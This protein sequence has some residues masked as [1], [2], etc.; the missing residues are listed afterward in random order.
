MTI[1]LDPGTVTLVGGGPG[2]PD[3][4]TVG[5]LR[6]LQQADVVLYDR[7]APVEALA[8]CRPDAELIAVGKVPRGPQTSQEEIN[9]L[10]VEHALAGQRV[11][12]FKGGDNFVFGRG[13]EE[14]QACAAHSIEVHVVPGVT[15]AV[16]VP[17]SVGIPVTHRSL[18]QGFIVVSGH[19][20]P[21]D[22]RCTVRWG[23]IARAG[24]TVVVLMGLHNAAAIVARLQSEGLDG[25]TPA[26][27]V[28]DGY[29]DGTRIRRT[30]LARLPE[31]AAELKPP[32][33]M[34]I[35][36]VA[37]LGLLSS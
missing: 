12:R 19:V 33:I 26:A 5:G 23:E 35:G 20:G 22:E 36:E 13:G 31:A 9:R 17:A 28:Q 37:Q 30:T 8:E 14:W 25:A 3:L 18:V 11:V 1:T 27:V 2:D 10:L 29:R 32:A 7:L 15:S 21:D 24:L 4:L 6:A 34:V 16:A